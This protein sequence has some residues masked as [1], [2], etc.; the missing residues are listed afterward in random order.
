MLTAQRLGAVNYLALLSAQQA[1]QQA[2]LT[3]VQAQ[4]TRLADTV[5]LFQALGGG[6]WNR[7]DRD[8]ARATATPSEREK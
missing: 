4:A 5:A 3:R 6:W 2:L 8:A 7:A 1:Y